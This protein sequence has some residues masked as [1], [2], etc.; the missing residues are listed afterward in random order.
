VVAEN[1]VMAVDSVVAEN[2]VMAV[3]SV[4]VV[5]LE[6]RPGEGQLRQPGLI[7]DYPPEKAELIRPILGGHRLKVPPSLA[8][9]SCAARIQPL[10]LLLSAPFL[11]CSSIR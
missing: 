11:P 8:T 3:D 9:A 5:A 1:S 10:P 2:S 4:A 7:R 6:N